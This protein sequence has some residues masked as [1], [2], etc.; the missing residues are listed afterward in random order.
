M[1]GK[2]PRVEIRPAVGGGFRYMF[3][4]G[5]KTPLAVSPET[6]ETEQGA[7]DC[8]A[9]AAVAAASL[10]RSGRP[11]DRIFGFVDDPTG[12]VGWFLRS[13]EGAMV[14][15]NPV[16]YSSLDEAE[17]FANQAMKHLAMFEV[18]AFYD[19]PAVFKKYHP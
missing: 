6:F 17:K 18:Q 4:L 9:E 11:D 10:V 12:H 15:R 16:P 8:F 14:G 3:W 5:D 1:W 7:R 13:P 19:A 2:K